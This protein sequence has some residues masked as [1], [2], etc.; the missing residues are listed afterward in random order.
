MSTGSTSERLVDG[1]AESL[2]S[3][4]RGVRKL[5]SLVG[6]VAVWWL[7]YQFGVLNFE[8]FV[9][10]TTTIV[11][12]V[13]ALAGEPMTEGGNTIYLHAVY[14]G[15]RVAVGVVVAALLAIPLGLVVGTSDR[16]ENL[17]YP[18]LEALRPIPPISWLPIAIIVFPALAIGAISVPLPALFVVFIGAFF[19]IFTNTIEGARTIE[20]EYTQA[21]R[22]L[23]ASSGNVFRHVVLPA[24]LPSIITGLSLGVGL[25]WITVVAAEL[26]TGGPGIGYIIIQGSR[27]LQNQVVVIGMLAVGALGY[28]SSALVEALGR[29]LTPWSREQS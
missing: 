8:H 11:E 2:P 6:F 1:F 14:S 16:W 21:A 9:S 15:A 23:G 18:A 12:F 19:P 3:P 28:A 29:W 20:T 7:F 25:G 13:G 26:L 22:S 24:T 4:T 17:L 10:P 5:I 27:L